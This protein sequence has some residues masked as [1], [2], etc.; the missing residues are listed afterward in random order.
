MVAVLIFD[1]VY[2]F[3][4]KNHSWKIGYHGNK[5]TLL[6]IYGLENFANT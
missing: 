4:Q 1:H 2:W 3:W 5:E 6:P